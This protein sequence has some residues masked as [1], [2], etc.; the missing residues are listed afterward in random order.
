MYKNKYEDDLQTALLDLP[1][2]VMIV[3]NRIPDGDSLGACAAILEFLRNE[4]VEAYV[5]CVVEPSPGL[6]WMID[7]EDSCKEILEDYNSLVVVDDEVDANRLGITIKDVPIVNIDHHMGNFPEDQRERISKSV[8]YRVKIG[9]TIHFW[10]DVPAT[11]CL[12]IDWDILH[13]YLWVS[14]YT[15]SVGF[16]VNCERAIYYAGELSLALDLKNEDME[17]MLA[18]LKTKG[19][20]SDLFW[21]A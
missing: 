1:E 13:P 14:L 11:A 18:K 17:E 4:G 12:L 2:P 5:H 21:R 9:Q 10:A 7:E 8:S 15:D 3:G 16:T 20:L 19:T 6:A